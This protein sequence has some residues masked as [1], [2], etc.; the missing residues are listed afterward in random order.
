[1]EMINIIEILRAYQLVELT[2][3][4]ILSKI[5]MVGY[6]A[7]EQNQI[8]MKNFCKRKSLQKIIIDDYGM[9]VVVNEN[10]YKIIQILHQ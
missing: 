8:I 1:M 9:L 2:W 3:Q 5:D 4:N 7:M 6:I 10:Q